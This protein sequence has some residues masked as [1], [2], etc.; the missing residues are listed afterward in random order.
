MY[1]IYK[2]SCS[3]TAYERADL[4]VRG[5]AYEFGY[6]IRQ[7]NFAPRIAIGDVIATNSND[8]KETVYHCAVHIEWQEEG[9]ILIREPCYALKLPDG[10]TVECV[11][12][13]K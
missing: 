9:E 10:V 5:C 8:N 2:F 12:F 6:I 1:R 4:I 11:P 13:G 3:S 7:D